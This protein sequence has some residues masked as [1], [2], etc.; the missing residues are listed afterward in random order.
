MPQI[1]SISVEEYNSA[2]ESGVRCLTVLN[3][4]KTKVV[5]HWDLQ[6]LIP[7]EYLLSPRALFTVFKKSACLI[8]SQL[9]ILYSVR[10]D[11]IVYWSRTTV[12]ILYKYPRIQ[13]LYFMP[14][15]F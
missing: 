9:T 2:I 8:S 5:E 10:I 1:C 14:K 3:D 6:K 4:D 15:Q 11:F 12:F 13:W 7:F